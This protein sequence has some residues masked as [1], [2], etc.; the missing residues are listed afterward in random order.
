MGLHICTGTRDSLHQSMVF[1][2]ADGTTYRDAGSAELTHQ[3]RFAGEFLPF[4]VFTGSDVAS[5]ALKNLAIFRSVPD[6][7]A[8]RHT[9]IIQLT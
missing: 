5:Q 4:C 2:F 3:G 8:I 1:Q 7:R 6:N 9:K